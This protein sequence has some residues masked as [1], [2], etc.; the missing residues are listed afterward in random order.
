MFQFSHRLIQWFKENRVS[1]SFRQN[2]SPYRV[3]ISEVVLQQTRI[4]YALKSLEAF[5]KN[6]PDLNRLAKASEEEVLLSFKGLGYYNRAR[7][8]LKGAKYICNELGGKFPE[9]YSELINI[10]SIGDYTAAAISSICFAERRPAIDGN[11][12][13]VLA[14]FL[15]LPED[16]SDRK[17]IQKIEN[18]LEPIFKEMKEHPGDLNEALM[19]LGQKIC[20][21]KNPDCG[22]CPLKEECMAFINKEQNNYPRKNINKKEIRVI[23]LVFI[24]KYGDKIL[25]QKNPTSYFLKDQWAFPSFIFFERDHQLLPTYF[26]ELPQEISKKLFYR[27]RNIINNLKKNKK[28]Q[29][30]KHTITH[31]KIKIVTDEFDIK[32][33]D[34]KNADQKQ[35]KWIKIK[36][37]ARILVSHAMQKSWK[38]Y[39][40]KE[41]IFFKDE[42]S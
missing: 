10:P 29:F 2:R 17:F 5:L 26:K 14:R 39:I 35:M 4:S 7:N 11:V 12:K 30:E 27:A 38:L 20:F 42:S 1:Y 6:F 41:S 36:N 19:E 37:V 33:E 23:W 24:V 21:S 25:L 40:Q 18:F 16:I 32:L 13:R 34:A 15:M 31:H 3:W 22:I 28:F 9:K 8:I